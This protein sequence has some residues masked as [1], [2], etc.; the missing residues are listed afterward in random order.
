MAAAFKAKCLEFQSTLP[1]WGKTTGALRGPILWAISIHS[2]RMGRD[3]SFPPPA[4]RPQQFQSTLPAWGETCAR[5][6]P[7]PKDGISI[8]SP[9]MGRDHAR[10]GAGGGKH[11]ISIHSPRMGR[12]IST[13][14]Q[15]LKEPFQSTLPAWG[16]TGRGSMGLGHR[17]YFNPLSPHGK[18]QQTHTTFRREKL[19]HLHN[20]VSFRQQRG[21]SC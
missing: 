18:R 11:P 17:I 15:Y 13:Y 14:A 21:S 4:A 7:A 6:P 3:R 9:R 10:L 16:E 12:D 5:G 2:P 20:I 1:A 8:H 19:A